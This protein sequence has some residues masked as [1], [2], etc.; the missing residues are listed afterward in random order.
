MADDYFVCSPYTSN[1]KA[2][3]FGKFSEFI[4]YVI[5]FTVPYY[6]YRIPFPQYPF[7]K[8]DYALGFILILSMIPAIIV[9]KRFPGTLKSSLWSLLGLYL[10]INLISSLFT[11]YVST[12]VYGIRMILISYVYLAFILIFVDERGFTR[13]LPSVLFISLGIATAISAIGF[14]MRI[15]GLHVSIG[16]GYIRGYGPTIGANNMALMCNF[17]FPVLVHFLLY[18][19]GGLRRLFIFFVLFSVFLGFIATYS[20]G[21]F[22]TFVVTCLFIF[23][24]NIHHLKVRNLGLF[25]AMIG[26]IFIIGLTF[27]PRSYYQRILSISH[28]TKQADISVRRRRA[29]ITVAINSIKKHPFLGTGPYTFLDVWVNSASAR[30]F[31]WVRR[32]AHNTYLEVLVGSGF[33]GFAIFL[34][35]LWQALK[36]YTKAKKLFLESGNERL[37]SLTGAYRASYLSILVYFFMKSAFHHKYFLL[38]LALSEVALRIAVKFQAE[39]ADH[40]CS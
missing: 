23:V 16:Q 19:R 38:G 29:Y 12:S 8:I 31:E 40:Q 39:R 7:F 1:E 6:R 5:I 3:P 30:R 14:Y 13:I 34:F 15:P 37:A 11:P 21:G 2:N 4:F 33:P 35:L 22:I 17:T 27:V 36:N 25:L 9:G 24:E 20:R 26:I 32:P 28:G 18:E 10:V